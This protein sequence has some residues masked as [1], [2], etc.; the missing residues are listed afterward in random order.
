ML[1]SMPFLQCCT[2]QLTQHL[3]LLHLPSS[4]SDDLDDFARIADTY[5]DGSIRLTCEENILFPNIPTA[6]LETMLAEPMF[7]RFTT[8]PG[9]LG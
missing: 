1:H 3:L 8:Q 2:S 4:F 6:K 5:G 7:E 9:T